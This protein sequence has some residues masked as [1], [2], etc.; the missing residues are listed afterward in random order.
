MANVKVRLIVDT[1]N[2]PKKPT[3]KEYSKYCRI[4]DNRS[5]I[6]GIDPVDNITEVSAGQ[7]IEWSGTPAN[8]Y[9]MDVVSI[10]S[11]TKDTAKGK[12]DMFGAP[13]LIGQTGVIT[14]TILGGIRKGDEEVYTIRFSII[15]NK[16]GSNTSYAIDPKLSGK[17]NT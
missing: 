15:K 13:V 9:T 2:I 3:Q 16:D 4:M 8:P 5:S 14:A 6:I 11:I 1:E 10:D 12:F 7:M 17:P